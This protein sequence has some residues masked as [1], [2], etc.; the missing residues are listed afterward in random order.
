MNFCPAPVTL[1]RTGSGCVC[2]SC[3][4]CV[5]PCLL[6]T[7]RR[8]MKSLIALVTAT[9]DLSHSEREWERESRATLRSGQKVF[10]SERVTKFSKIQRS[11]T[12]Y[13]TESKNNDGVADRIWFGDIL[14]LC[15]FNIKNKNSDWN[16]VSPISQ[17]PPMDTVSSFLS[18]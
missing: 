14:W 5:H 2:V 13:S 16:S 6:L 17:L 4:L 12:K 15:A 10:G 11:D 18:F 8:N 1:Q 9:S 3:V 7:V